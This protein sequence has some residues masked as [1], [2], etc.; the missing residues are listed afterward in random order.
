[1]IGMANDTNEIQ[2]IEKSLT[3]GDAKLQEIQERKKEL[4]LLEHDILATREKLIQR[5]KELKKSEISNHEE[6]AND[7]C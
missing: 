5:I 1:M 7:D 3:F 6:D 4:T 2:Q